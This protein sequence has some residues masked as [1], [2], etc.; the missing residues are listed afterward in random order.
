MELLIGQRR[1]REG[2]QELIVCH[3]VLQRSG[4]GDLPGMG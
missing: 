4:Y 1:G 2:M 3:G